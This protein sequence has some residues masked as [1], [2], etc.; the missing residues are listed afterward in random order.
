[1]AKS[2]RRMQRN[3]VRQQRATEIVKRPG[4]GRADGRAAVTTTPPGRA[5]PRVNQM[6]GAQVD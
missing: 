1:M 5:G 6:D 3:V 2:G 4:P